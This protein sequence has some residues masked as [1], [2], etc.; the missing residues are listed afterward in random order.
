MTPLL[1]RAL[2]CVLAAGSLAW[3]APPARALAG[4]RLPLSAGWAL[5]DSAQIAVKGDALSRPGASVEGWYRI[6]VPNTV[7]GALV[8]PTAPTR[9]PTSA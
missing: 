9:T 5:Q 2:P 3:A 7:V 4:D 6:S 8:E 1:G